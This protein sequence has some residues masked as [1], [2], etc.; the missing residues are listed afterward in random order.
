MAKKTKKGRRSAPAPLKRN[1]VPVSPEVSAVTPQ[2]RTGTFAA[3]ARSTV[4]TRA[5]AAAK[6]DLAQE[7]GY[8]LADLRKI[9][10][11]AV[12][13]FVLLFA[14]VNYARFLGINPENA[15]R[16]T[17]GEF[18]RRFRSIE[19]ELRREGKDI[20]QTTLEEMDELG[21]LFVETQAGI[22]PGGAQLKGAPA[23]H[24][25]V[26]ESNSNS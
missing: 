16:R 2:T 17:V 24:G 25:A 6:A 5:A 4:A 8:V 12:V 20:H 14:L 26:P 3:T 13:M 15:L 22:H 19:V 23:V 9:A 21:R 1:E 18:S 11:I 7:Y 10:I